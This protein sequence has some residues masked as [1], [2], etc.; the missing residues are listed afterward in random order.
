MRG[1]SV[2]TPQG[3]FKLAAIK[4][5]LENG[6]I[7]EFAFEGL[8]G[9]APTGPVKIG[10][11]ALKSLDLAGLLR[12]TALFSNPAQQPPP[13]QLLGL[14][15]LLAGIEVKGFVAPFKN[16]NKL[17]TLDSFNLNWG[18][19]VGPVP[20]QARLT[21]KVTTP[22]DANDPTSKPLL[23]AGIDAL[24]VDTDLGAA[25]TESSRS[26]LLEPVDT[27]NRRPREGFRARLAR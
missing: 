15:P 20:S 22:V 7:G 6:K 12:M 25:W 24:T 1:L 5:N 11:F 14:F 26:F 27:R 4:F 19:F 3:P 10:R 9:R 16:T 18:Q 21:G 2:D 8:D 23:V 17:V 13:D